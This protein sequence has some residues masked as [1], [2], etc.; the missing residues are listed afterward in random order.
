[1]IFRANLSGK[2]Q[3]FHKG[4]RALPH[5]SELYRFEAAQPQRAFIENLTGLYQRYTQ[6]GTWG[7]KGFIR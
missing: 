3:T 2:I 1:M 5:R 6:L 7:E 4:L